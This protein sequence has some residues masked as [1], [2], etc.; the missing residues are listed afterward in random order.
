[1]RLP[2]ILVACS[3]HMLLVIAPLG[4][5]GWATY[6]AVRWSLAR[7]WPAVPCVITSSLVN[8]VSRDNPYVFRVAYRYSRAGEW[9]D[10]RTY[11]EEY[12]GSPNIAE[13]DA[14]ARAFPIGAQ[15]VCYVNPRNPAEAVLEHENV[16]IAAL[17]AAV[18]WLI[19]AG[20]KSLL[21]PF[22]RGV[23]ARGLF[24]IVLGLGCYGFFF[25]LPL[26]RGLRSLGWRPTRC[27][28]QSGQVRSTTH[29]GAISITIYR[30]DVI[31]QYEVNGVSYRANTYNASDVGSPWYYGAR[32]VV[33]HHAPGLQTTCFVDPADPSAAVMARIP[34]GT[35]WFGV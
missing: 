8:E 12:R 1:M 35:Q 16:W 2:P 25:G 19:V 4:I 28:V 31:Y 5:A 34:S 3:F 15:R 6:T 32:G 10:G 13:A 27:V 17:L 23:M 18:M 9:Y 33:R 21:N 14:L 24:L 30:P 20:L 26:S 11:R 22:R 29:H 7:T